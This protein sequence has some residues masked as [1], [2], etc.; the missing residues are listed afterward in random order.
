MYNVGNYIETS[1]TGCYRWYISRKVSTFMDERCLLC[2]QKPVGR[3]LKY[4][5]RQLT[6]GASLTFPW[7]LDPTGFPHRAANQNRANA[8]TSAGKRRGWQ[9]FLHGTPAG[10]VVTRIK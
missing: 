1:V 6:V 2:N 7:M 10:L 5:I 9:L 4:D 8:I 3:R